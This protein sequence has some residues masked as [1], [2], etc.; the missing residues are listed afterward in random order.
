M[1][2]PTIHVDYIH[3][4]ALI[5]FLEHVIIDLILKIN[6]IDYQTKRRAIAAMNKFFWIQNH[7]FK[8]HYEEK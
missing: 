3:I 8:M 2:T 7:F 6:N 5:G 1:G 4:S